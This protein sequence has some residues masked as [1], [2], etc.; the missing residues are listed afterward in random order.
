MVWIEVRVTESQF[1]VLREKQKAFGV[2]TP[3]GVVQRLI[4]S[5]EVETNAQYGSDR[6]CEIGR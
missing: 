6:A 2:L 4:R 5:L 3:A 1:A